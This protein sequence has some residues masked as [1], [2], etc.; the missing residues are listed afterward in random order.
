[1]SPLAQFLTIDFKN[2]DPLDSKFDILQFKDVRLGKRFRYKYT[3]REKVGPQQSM[4]YDNGIGICYL[5]IKPD[6]FVLILKGEPTET[7][8]KLKRAKKI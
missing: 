3:W 4:S 7:L 1:M 5:S 6:E 8:L 2:F